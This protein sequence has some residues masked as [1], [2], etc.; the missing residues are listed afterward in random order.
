MYS[1]S[2]S[3][4]LI[5]PFVKTVD[6]PT[7]TLQLRRMGKEEAALT[8]RSE[9]A[10]ADAARSRDD[11]ERKRSTADALR[12]EVLARLVQIIDVI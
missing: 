5:L 11:F 9:A 6:Q 7:F 1:F 2:I 8:K 12:G 10:S 4:I 3:Q